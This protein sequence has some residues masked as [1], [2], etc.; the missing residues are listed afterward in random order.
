MKI[1]LT[2]YYRDLLSRHQRLSH[3]EGAATNDV[4][5]SQ[6]DESV[7][8]IQNKSRLPVNIETFA[9]QELQELNYLPNATTTTAVAQDGQ[10]P[11]NR[12]FSTQ[13]MSWIP[14]PLDNEYHVMPNMM[15]D[16]G[17]IPESQFLWDNFLIADQPAPSEFFGTDTATM[18][19]VA[20]PSQHVQSSFPFNQMSSQ[21]GFQ[22][23]N[24]SS[25]VTDHGQSDNLRLRLP[26]LEPAIQPPEEH[27]REP[28]RAPNPKP[29]VVVKTPWKISTEDY[30]RITERLS[31]AN[32]GLLHSSNFPSRHTLSRYL[33]GYFRGF[34]DH[35]PFLHM[36]SFSAV[37]LAPEL[38]LSLAAMGAFY[39]FEHSQGH[40]LYLSARKAIDS[41]ID[42]IRAEEAAGTQGTKSSGLPILQGLIVLLTLASWG[43]NRLSRDAMSL[44]S[45]VVMLARD[46]GISSQEK[47]SDSPSWESWIMAEERCRTLWSAYSLLTLQNIISDMTPMALNREISMDLPSCNCVWRAQNSVEWAQYKAE[48]TLSFP[49]VLRD[50]LSGVPIHQ[51][52]LISSFGNY[53]LIVAIIQQVFLARLGTCQLDDS[54]SPLGKESIQIMETTLLLWQQSWEATYESTLDPSSPKGPMGFNSTAPLRLA[55]IRLNSNVSPASRGI[56]EETPCGSDG[57]MKAFH[58]PLHRSS[59]TDRAVLQCIYALS[60]PVRV[61]VAFVARTQ[62]LHWSAQHAIC[63][64]ECAFFL[65]QW[66]RSLSTR[67][68]GDVYYNIRLGLLRPDEQ[69][70]LDMLISLIRETDMASTVEYPGPQ[71]IIAKGL[72]VA[73][74]KLWAGTIEGLQVFEIVQK[75]GERLQALSAYL[76]AERI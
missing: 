39:R 42:A 43:D 4:T 41:R 71:Q 35:F 9:A 70:L 3:S 44:S 59:H 68:D 32:P 46:L 5:P 40:K 27:A 11:E 36:T 37:S 66:L 21:P 19:Q 67:E 45:Q 49:K 23:R 55:Y 50:L 29:F 53:V 24:P 31:S 51:K 57:F 69:R 62:T 15:L 8:E 63:T 12:D 76:Q 20:G 47:V 26:S 48:E 58:K 61:G 17:N 18:N 2:R 22:D 56:Y 75:V 14:Q 38:L 72:I 73:V 60:V 13:S 33:E 34:H 10:G 7:P 65:I 74:A 6:L 54:E 25:P 28:N 64:L 16:Y 30:V 52:K 1:C